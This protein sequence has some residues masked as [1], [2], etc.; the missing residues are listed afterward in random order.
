MK[1]LFVLISPVLWSLKNDITRFN[2]SFYRKAFF[3]AAVCSVFIVLLTKLLNVG[4]MKLQHMS[5]EVF[6]V[7]LTKGYSLIFV[8]IF[9][10]QI[11]NGFALSLNTYY[12]SKDLEILFTS[13]VNRTSLFLSKLFETHIKASW[14]LIIFGVPLLVSSG[15]LHHVNFLSYCYGLMLFIAF[16]II[17]VNLGIGITIV[18]SSVFHIRRMKKYFLSAGV[19]GIVLVVTLLRIFRPER[20][21][22]PELFANL[23]LFLSEMKTPSFIVLPSRWLSEA[24]FA[25]LGN[26]WNST[27]L[28][29]IALLFLTPYV[30]TLL[31]YFVF[32]RYHSR[33]WV[34]LQEGGNLS[35]ERKAHASLGLSLRLLQRL[36]GMLDP[37]S[38]MLVAKDLLCQARDSKNI[39]QLLILVSLIIIYLFSIASLPLNWEGYATQLK[40]IIAFFNLGLILIIIASLCVRLVYPGVVSEGST[41]WIMKTSPVT[42]KRYLWTKFLFFFIPV[43]VLGQVL[44]VFSSL[45]IG[46]EGAFILLIISTTALLSVSLVSI[47]ITFGIADVKRGISVSQEQGRTGSTAHMLVSIILILVTL[48]LEVIPLF[49]YFLK[50]TTRIVFTQRA[51]IMIGGVIVAVVILNVFVAAFSMRKSIRGIGKLELS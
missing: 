9:F 38:R 27:T 21:V 14:M 39:H 15:L 25:F 11:L 42:P 22:N 5:P 44:T 8:I 36:T 41:L 23:T 49:L 6:S 31:I 45:F 43:F 17:P 1:E 32:M 2:R 40:Y 12:Q 48:A 16:S 50:E 35:R 3:Y 29:F 26:T 4:I 18:L 24:V 34:Q 10:I 33:G 19:I 46:I 13:P 30:T 47:A 20:F 28:I 51:W 7:L 37:K